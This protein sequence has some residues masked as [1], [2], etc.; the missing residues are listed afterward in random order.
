MARRADR[1]RPQV[2]R[3]ELE[4]QNESLRKARSE[5]ETAL[6]RSTELF[7]FAPIGYA[8]V[9][10]DDKIRDVNHL[11]ATLLGKERAHLVGRPLDAFVVPKHRA[12]LLALLRGALARPEAQK[13][14]VELGDQRRTRLTAAFTVNALPGRSTLLLALEDVTQR[15]ANDEKLARVEATLRDADHRKD[16]FLATLSHEL[17][18]PLA[19]IRSSLMFLTMK[20]PK[21]PAQTKQAGEVI[22]RQVEHLSRL[23]DDLL[24][25]T[26]IAR[27]KVQLRLTDL[28]LRRL[29]R[30]CTRDQSADFSRLGIR[31]ET[32]LG[33]RDLWVRGDATRLAQAVS[34]LLGNAMKFTSPG[35]HVLLSL[36]AV[37]RRAQIVLRDDGAGIDP[38]YLPKIFDPFSQGPLLGER[39]RGGLGL[40]LPMVKGLVELHRGAVTVTSPGRGRGT[41]VTFSLPLV[42]RPRTATARLSPLRRTRRARRVL[43]IEDNVDAADSLQAVLQAVGHEVQVSRDGASGIERA[44]DYRPEVILCDIGLPDLDGYTVA[45]ALRGEPALTGTCLVALSGY[46]RDQDI[47]KAEKSGFDRHLT[48]PADFPRLLA[49]LETARRR[50]RPTSARPRT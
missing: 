49:L 4:L 41:E 45:R 30:E 23:V 11:A 37:G 9:D 47:E 5:L 18:N 31:L 24:D 17:R 15:R 22:A 28:E 33:A 38:D 20:A 7:V 16:D 13:G 19:P 8:V 40:G 43:L 1:E 26:R 44:R 12:G 29:L 35:G 10:R 2:H 46:G 48:K 3:S 36:R 27:G 50:P 21:T 25:V 39:S 34:N 32:R 14:E 42:E 6:A